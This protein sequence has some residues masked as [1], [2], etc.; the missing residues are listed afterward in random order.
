MANLYTVTRSSAFNVTDND[1]FLKLVDE[2]GHDYPELQS[3]RSYI[4]PNKWIIG[5]EFENED[6]LEIFDGNGILDKLQEL[7]PKDEAVMLMT[8]GHEKL[9]YIYSDVYMITKND[10]QYIDLADEAILLA[11]RMIGDNNKTLIFD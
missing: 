3:W 8:I 6:I 9:R 11:R 1:K 7:L 10:I 4:D 2:I 5:G